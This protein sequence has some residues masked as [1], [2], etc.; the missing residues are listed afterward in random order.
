[1]GR[2]EGVSAS[3]EALGSRQ[4]T[5]SL[6]EGEACR[7][8]TLSR[9]SIRP[10]AGLGGWGMGPIIFKAPLSIWASHSSRWR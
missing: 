10:P 3:A 4:H 2:A 6:R 5:G 1:M 9:R 7:F 8:Q